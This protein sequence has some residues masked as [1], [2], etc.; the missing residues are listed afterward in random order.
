MPNSILIL[1]ERDESGLTVT[2]RLIHLYQFQIPY[3]VGP[4]YRRKDE[5]DGGRKWVERKELGRVLMKLK[6]RPGKDKRSI[7]HE[8][9]TSLQFFEW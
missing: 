5:S 2:E 7:H 6:G 4:L 3:Y 1:K 9:G 8:H